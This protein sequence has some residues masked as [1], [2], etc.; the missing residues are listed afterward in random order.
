MYCC[1]VD[2]VL[3]VSGPVE[4]IPEF[5]CTVFLSL[6]AGLPDRAWVQSVPSFPSVGPLISF[7]PLVVWL[8]FF[9]RGGVG[10]LTILVK[11]WCQLA[12]RGENVAKI[13]AC[14]R[15]LLLL[16]PLRQTLS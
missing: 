15:W 9:W 4:Y 13:S 8:F 12:T 10:V 1:L 6:S 14:P 5:R 7:C 11:F 3:S 2:P 16:S